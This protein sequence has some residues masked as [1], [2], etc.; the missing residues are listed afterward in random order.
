MQAITKRE[1]GFKDDQLVVGMVANYNRPV[2]G[3]ANFLDAIPSIVAAVPSAGFYS[4]EEGMKKT[5]CGI[6]QESS[7]GTLRRLRRV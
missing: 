1:L 4:W 2:K 7:G 6:R 5:P 3:V